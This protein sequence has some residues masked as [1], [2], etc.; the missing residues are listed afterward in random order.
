VTVFV[1]TSALLPILDPD[2]DAHRV[3]AETFSSL[4]NEE[5]LVAHNY[6]VVETAAL[7]QR[8]LPR[9][10]LR[11]LLEDIIPLVEV[12]WIGIETHEAAVSA[13]LRGPGR[14]TS[15]VDRVSFEVMRRHAMETA[16][17]FDRDFAE[18]GFRTVP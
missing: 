4:L 16:F 5:P 12:V 17:A 1:D 8:R 18:E 14:R 2:D 13:F 11:V 15:L 3:A 10:Q 7:V 9:L 6:V